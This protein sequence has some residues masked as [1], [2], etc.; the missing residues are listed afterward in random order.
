MKPSGLLC[1]YGRVGMTILCLLIPSALA[2][3]SES[4]TEIFLLSYLLSNLTN[5]MI[6]FLCKSGSLAQAGLELP[7]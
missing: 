6:Y 7:I 4:S 1:G 3:I 2:P 5:F